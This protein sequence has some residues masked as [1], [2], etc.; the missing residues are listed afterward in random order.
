M[1]TSHFEDLCRHKAYV[2]KRKLPIRTISKETGLSQGAILR[3]KNLKLERVYL[4]TLETL[5]RYFAVKS[6][7]EL[8]EYVPDTEEENDSS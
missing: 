6:L 8:I 5:C 1:M 3:V 2:E 7:S 4:S